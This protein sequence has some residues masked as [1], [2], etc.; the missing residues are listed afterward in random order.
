MSQIPDHGINTQ[1]LL[2]EAKLEAYASAVQDII[3]LLTVEFNHKAFSVPAR[4]CCWSAASPDPVKFL[5][6]LE[7]DAPY[8]AGELVEFIG[9]PFEV[10]WPDK[11]DANAGEFQFKVEG[12]GFELDSDLE[13]AALSGGEI[14]AIVRVF[15]KG[16]EKEGPAEVYHNINIKNPSIDATTG[17]ITANGSFMDWINRTYGYNYT[18]GKYP[19]LVS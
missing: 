3:L 18:P 5:C 10:Q 4:V 19:A 16:R 1:Q 7:N 6:R 15:I 2:D 8:N 17:T 13:A 14:T 12:A 9:L 11:V